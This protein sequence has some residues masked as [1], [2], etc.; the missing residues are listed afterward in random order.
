[1]QSLYICNLC[2]NSE[3]Q[4]YLKL[5]VC[6]QFSN[7]KYQIVKCTKCGLKS[8]YPIPDS[9]ELQEI[10]KNYLIT[11]SRE[12]TEAKRINIYMEKLWLLKKYSNGNKLLDIGAG[13][14]TFVY[15]ANKQGFD[16]IG[17]E[18]SKE[19]CLTALNK[20]NIKL[21]NS[22]F[23]NIEF[24]KCLYD[25]VNMNHVLEHLVSPFEVLVKIHNILKPNGLLLIEVP[26]QFDNIFVNIKKKLT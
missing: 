2:R 16:A 22:K 3:Y 24:E 26:N 7:V 9:D 13:I 4:I 12:E 18:Q 5:N 25:I 6:Q 23:E 11:S 14:G 15:I 1:M 20:Y 17:V 21:I 10:Y 8:L 19:L